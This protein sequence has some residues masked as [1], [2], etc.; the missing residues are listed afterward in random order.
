MGLLLLASVLF[1]A[2]PAASGVAIGID[3]GT[4]YSC[5]AVYRHGK[6]E[7]IPNDQGNRITPSWI[8]FTPAGERLVGDAAKNQAA[9][10]PANTVYDAK[11]LIGRKFDEDQVAGDVAHFPFHV[12]E[13]KD[14]SP[15]IAVKRRDQELLL[16][17]AEVSALVLE[18][19]KSIAEEYIGE[20]VTDAVIT[21]PAYFNDNQRQATKDAGRIAGLTVLRVLNE[22]TAAAIAFGLDGKLVTRKVIVFDLGGG[23]FDVSLL[24]IDKGDFRVLAT[25]GNTHLGGA[26]FDQRVMDYFV[27]RF[28]LKHQRDL[29]T[30]SK[31]MAKL[32]REA[33]RAKRAL[34]SE[35][36]V[37]VEI[38]S[39]MDDIDF[40]ET[41]TRA[42]F[43]ELCKDLFRQ[44]V[45]PIQK[46]L[47][48]T[49]T[50]P[51]EIDDVVLVGGST[52]IPY[53][54][55]MVMAM[56]K[57]KK[58]AAGVNPDEAVA[59]GAAV[60]AAVLSGAHMKHNVALHDVTP[61]SL[62]IKTA[63]NMMSVLI[64]RNTPTPATKERTFSTFKDHQ[65]MVSVNVYEGERTL[66]KDNHF[67]G[68]FD[69]TGIEPA[70][71]GQRKIRVTFSIDEDGIL[72][73]EAYVVGHGSNSQSLTIDSETSRLSE[74]DIK[75]M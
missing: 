57:N 12:Q 21:V 71:R 17:P 28:K 47:S 6:V 54:Q 43:E 7:I 75:Q 52:R 15:A 20:E 16:S 8:A 14:G 69:L 13:G 59:Y 31:A 40:K 23:T 74:A 11:R 62:G 9:F 60:Q 32:R 30:S 63:G 18:K 61:L 1:A 44:T 27:G 37:K 42:K 39:I 70:P 25:S 4:T 2:L 49:D 73:V 10:N 55:K 56:F 33:E 45:E 34:S 5:V 19:M 67:L 26:D 64:K 38:P 35:V 58:P 66:V 51:K 53:I 41:L 3:L 22:P 48:D 65:T 36:T 72:S 46:V 29:T 50:Y 24:M 68:K